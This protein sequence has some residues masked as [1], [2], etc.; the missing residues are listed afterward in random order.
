MDHGELRT[1][2]GEEPAAWLGSPVPIGTVYVA[3]RVWEHKNGQ[4]K[5]EK[6]FV[7]LHARLSFL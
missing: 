4:N 2:Q 7:S 6:Y 3:A 5:N 1:F